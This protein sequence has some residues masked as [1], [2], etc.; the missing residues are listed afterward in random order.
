MLPP[1][2]IYLFVWPF[3]ESVNT[4]KWNTKSLS[5]LTKE[6]ENLQIKSLIGFQAFELVASKTLYSTYPP[7]G[8]CFDIK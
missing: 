8:E 2:G 7:A 3:W 6:W 1:V 4:L 5:S